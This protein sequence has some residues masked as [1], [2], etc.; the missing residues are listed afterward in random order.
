MALA[1]LG[2]ALVRPGTHR[3]G[4]GAARR[5]DDGRAR[6]RGAAT[7]WPAATPAAPRWSSATAS[8]TSTARP[9][10]ARRSS[11][12]PSAAASSPC[13]RGAAASSAR[14]WSARATGSAPRP[15]S[16]RRSRGSRIA[17]GRRPRAAARGARRPAPAAGPREEAE[18]LLDGLEDEPAALA[19]L[20]Q[21][22][23]QRGEFESPR[24]CSTDGR[25]TASVLALRGAV[26]LAAGDLDAAER[27]GRAPARRRRALAR[28]PRGP[29]RALAGGV[30]ARGMPTAA[31]PLEDAVR[32]LRR[33]RAPATRPRAPGSTLAEAQAAA[34]SPLALAAARAA[35]DAFERLGAL[36]RRR[37]RG[38]AAARAR[39]RRPHRPRGE[40]DELTARERR[41]CG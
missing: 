16:P 8:P 40:R 10:G 31:E 9:S 24:R 29:R 25:R 4:H 7:R 39:R 5:G 12:S 14:C 35:R 6:R 2:R 17:R 30:A 26:A 1:Q 28:R 19:A 3:G 33:A 18:R 34:G 41:C 27:R 22:H 21:L 23:L 11:S 37:P 36:P 38:R 15:S 13:S 32:R 20:V